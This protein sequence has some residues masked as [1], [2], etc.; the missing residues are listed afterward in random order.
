MADWTLCIS[1]VGHLGDTQ[2]RASSITSRSPAALSILGLAL[3]HLQH[4][5]QESRVDSH[6]E[7]M[8]HLGVERKAPSQLQVLMGW[9][10]RGL[11]A[12]DG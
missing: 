10:L 3:S 2:Q 9:G 8:L 1:S 4:K 5:M 7:I 6:L 12:R 11:Q